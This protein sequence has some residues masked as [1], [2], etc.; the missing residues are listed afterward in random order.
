VDKLS[1]RP[2][3]IP[4][5]SDVDAPQTAKEFFD[6]VVRHHGL[7]AM[8]IS[9]RDSKFTSTYWKSLMEIMDIR[10][11]M[12]TAGRA[13]ADQATERQNRTLKDALSRI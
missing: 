3:Y 1:K 7:P 9:D 12:T 8:I 13:Q 11:A 4:T 6:H 2:K 5:R 10:Q